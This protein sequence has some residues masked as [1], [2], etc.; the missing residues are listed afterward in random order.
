MRASWWWIDRWRANPARTD[1]SYEAIGVYRELRDELWLRDGLLPADDVTLARI[2]GDDA[3]WLR[4]KD[5]VLRLFVRTPEGYR[6]SEHDE[7]SAESKKRAEKQ[8]R[9][10]SRYQ[11][12]TGNV[13]PSPSQSPSQ[14]QN[15]EHTGIS[16]LRS[17]IPPSS[18][19]EAGTESAQTHPEPTPAHSEPSE[20]A[21]P[22]SLFDDREAIS[23]TV[24]DKHRNRSKATAT[25]LAAK[26]DPETLVAHYH[27]ILPHLPGVR[28]P[29]S[30]GVKSAVVAALG[31]DP[32]EVWVERF[33]R[34][35]ESDFLSGRKA[36]WKANLLWLLGPRN[37][38]K[39]DAG[40]YD[41]HEAAPSTIS[42][43]N[44]KALRASRNIRI[45]WEDGVGQ[46]DTPEIDYQSDPQPLRIAPPEPEPVNHEAVA[47]FRGL[48]RA[49]LNGHR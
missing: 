18:R 33:E 3:V 30:H 44:A 7:V 22:A 45:A 38:A 15:R 29:L 1:L 48:S 10:R 31:R 9:Y 11:N 34:A 35:A 16:P 42:D 4:C 26:C 24:P 8:Q 36:D 23:P 2:V 20:N 27:R 6:S 19:P 41:N 46:D 12:K 47:K 21:T 43:Y 39:L 25:A 40:Q 37:A 14:S 49:L 13:T 17:E 5:A 28:V 32:V